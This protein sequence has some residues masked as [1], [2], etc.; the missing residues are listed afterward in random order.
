MIRKNYFLINIE[1]IRQNLA[2]FNSNSLVI[3]YL[4]IGEYTITASYY[5]RNGGWSVKQPILHVVV[6]SP[7]WKS[8]WFYAGLCILVGIVVYGIT[9]YFFR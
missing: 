6:V 7:W 3:N 8:N 9:F 1:G 2:N 5:T 4:P